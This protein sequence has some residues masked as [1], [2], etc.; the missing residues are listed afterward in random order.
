MSVHSPRNG[1]GISNF[2]MR[3]RDSQVSSSKMKFVTG[4][5]TQNKLN[6]KQKAN[7]GLT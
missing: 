3:R 1:G 7:K 5:K 2:S 6:M 4:Y